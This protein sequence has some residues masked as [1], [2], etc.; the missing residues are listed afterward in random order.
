VI[1]TRSYYFPATES[2]DALAVGPSLGR[3]DGWSPS[4]DSGS[5]RID[6]KQIRRWYAQC[7]R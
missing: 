1:V 3:I 7:E 5:Q 2:A 4:A 6:L